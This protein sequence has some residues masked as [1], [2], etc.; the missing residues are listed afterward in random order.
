MKNLSVKP[1]GPDDDKLER[2]QKNLHRC[3]VLENRF[4]WHSHLDYE[5]IFFYPYHF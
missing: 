1:K 5:T 2:D 3:F 4:E